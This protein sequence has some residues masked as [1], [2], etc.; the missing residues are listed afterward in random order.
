M[1]TST[2]SILMMML[3]GLAVMTFAHEHDVRDAAIHARHHHRDFKVA[4]DAQA[5]HGHRGLEKRHRSRKGHP[6]KH[7]GVAVASA[8]TAAVADTL[9]D[10]VIH[11]KSNCGNIGATKEVTATSGPNGNIDWLNCGVNNGGWN[12][13]F[14]TVHDIVAKDLASAVKTSNTPFSA[15]SAFTAMFEKYGNEHSIPPIMLAAFAMQESSCNANT[16]G[17]AGEQG[18]MQLTQDKC[19]GAPGGN[20]RDPEFN[21]RKGAEYFKGVLDGNGGDLL[22]AIGAYNGWQ[23]GMTYGEAT[24]ARYSGNC[25]W[26][27]NLDYLHQFLNGW[28][29]NIDAYSHVPRLGK[30]FNLDGCN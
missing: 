7:A 25:H 16:V 28:V 24:A 8:P 5:T 18:L 12:P 6:S 27:N 14:V 3:A 15:C 26:Q 13:P 30:Y 10:G 29:Q 11:V 9:V 23:R 20:C 17:G 4:G 1:K 19:G 21:I 2:S 22:L